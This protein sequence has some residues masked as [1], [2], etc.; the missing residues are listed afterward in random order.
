MKN[1]FLAAPYPKNA[2]FL[3]TPVA[4]TAF[5]PDC[6]PPQRRCVFGDPGAQLIQVELQRPTPKNDASSGTPDPAPAKAWLKFRAASLE[7]ARTSQ[8]FQVSAA[9]AYSQLLKSFVYIQDRWGSG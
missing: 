4:A 8:L 7:K 2:L 5:E 1:R 6:T 9:S 3:G